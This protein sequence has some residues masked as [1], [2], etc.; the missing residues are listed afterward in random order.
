MSGWLND[1]D[2]DSLTYSASS[3]PQGVSFDSQTQTFSWTPDEAGTYPNVHFEVSDGELTDSEDIPITINSVNQPPVADAGPDQTANQGDTVELDGSG[4]TDSDGMIVSYEWDFG[5]GSPTE[6]GQTVSYIYS[7][8]GTYT[9]T[10]TVTDDDGDV[11]MDTAQVTV[12]PVAPVTEEFSFSGNISR[13]E[14]E[15]HIVTISTPGAT[16]MS[17]KLTWSGWGD[18]VLRIYNPSGLLAKEVDQNTWRWSEETIIEN[19]E[20]GDWQVTTY[21]KRT[22]KSVSYSLQGVINY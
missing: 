18:L 19:L 1:T 14:E 8:A 10:L 4:S 3:R 9:A 22:G 6:T 21:A 7:A 12:N 5:D 2:G 16:S 20:P 17:I 13:G 11:D 15:A